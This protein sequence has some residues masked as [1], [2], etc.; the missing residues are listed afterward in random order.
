MYF[1]FDLIGFNIGKDIKIF[2][3]SHVS[4]GFY[5]I[6]FAVYL[7]YFTFVVTHRDILTWLKTAKSNAVYDYHCHGYSF[8]PS[9]F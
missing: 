7:Q 2:E 8:K 1:E 4:Q 3:I 6:L 5:Y 9:K